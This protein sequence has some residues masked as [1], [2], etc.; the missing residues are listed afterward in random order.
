MPSLAGRAGC[1]LARRAIDAGLE[2]RIAQATTT[3]L[4]DFP[5]LTDSGQIS[6]QLARVDVVNDGPARDLDDDVVA[7]TTGLVAARAWLAV[8]G[9]ELAG[10][11]KVRQ[12]VQG[13][14]CLEVDAAA[15]AAVAAVGAASLDVFLTSETEAAVATVAGLDADRGFVDEFHEWTATQYEKPRKGGVF[16][17][18]CEVGRLRRR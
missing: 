3:T 14:V 5:A 4:G 9:P 16:G 6:D 17:A 2:A 7:G 18:M 1:R 8:P 12:R 10:N 11:A 13:V 15:V